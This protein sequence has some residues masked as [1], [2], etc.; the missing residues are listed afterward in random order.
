MAD[1]FIICVSQHQALLT[2]DSQ[3]IRAMILKTANGRVSPILSDI[4]LCSL[5]LDEVTLANVCWGPLTNCFLSSLK[6]DLWAGGIQPSQSWPLNYGMSCPPSMSGWPPPC[7]LL[8][9][10]LK[11]IFTPWFLTQIESCAYTCSYCPLFYCVCVNFFFLGGWSGY[12]FNIVR[13]YCVII[14]LCVQHFVSSVVLNIL[15]K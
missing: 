10:V 12:T 14:Y 1:K 13:S 4:S 6:Q 8:H 7:L 5:L 15:Y 2:N 3:I 9:H 11:R